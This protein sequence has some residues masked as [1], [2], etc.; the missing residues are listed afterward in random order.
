MLSTIL[1]LATLT[2]EPIHQQS[3]SEI[4]DYLY[5]LNAKGDTFEQRVRKVTQDSLGTEYNDGPLGEG[6]GGKYDPDPII[7]LTRVDCVT[8]VEQTVALSMT[9]NYDE[10]VE[11]LQTIRYKDGKIDYEH[12]NHFMITDWLPNNPYCQDVSSQLGVETQTVKRTI[13][14]KDFFQ[15]VKAPTIGQS[16][17]DQT[18]SLNIISVKDT[19]HAEKNLPDTALI[20]FIGKID[21]LFSLHT[22]LYIRDE[23]GRGQLIHASS[24]SGKVVSMNL[25]DYTESQK[26]RYLGFTAYKITEPP[27]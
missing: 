17:P 19:A 5:L 20:I 7:D 4:T 27:M 14:R 8:F 13:S 21:W 11:F 18:I 1:I 15:L 22:G 10:M 2:A 12:R 24:K 23:N 3:P 6:V 25:T 26:T 9:P 16:T